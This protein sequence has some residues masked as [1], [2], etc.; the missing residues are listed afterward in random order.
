MLGSSKNGS[1]KLAEDDKGLRFDLDI[2]PTT[3]GNDAFISIDRGDVDGMS[4]RFNATKQEWDETDPENIVRTLV[5][6]E[7]DEISPTPFPAYEATVV[8]T[9]TAREDYADL[10]EQH[11]AELAQQAASVQANAND[12]DLRKKKLYLSI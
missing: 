11:A 8:N 10:K 5:E 7:C 6:L 9:R 3:A 4:F 1:L 2:A 12:I